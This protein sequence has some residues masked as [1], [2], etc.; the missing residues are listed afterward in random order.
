LTDL[1]DFV[2][3]AVRRR[4]PQPLLPVILLLLEE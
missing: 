1:L 3:P 4:G 2:E